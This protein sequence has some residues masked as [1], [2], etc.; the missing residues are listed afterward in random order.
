MARVQ[1]DAWTGTVQ[2]IVGK[3]DT[4][5]NQRGVYLWLSTDGKL[6]LTWSADGITPTTA[7]STAAVP[8][9]TG[10]T[11]WVRAQHDVDNGAAGNNVQFYTGT[12]GTNYTQLGGTVTTAGVTSHFASTADWSIGTRSLTSPID[13][14]TGRVYEVRIQSGLSAA[15]YDVMPNLPELYEPLNGVGGTGYTLGGSPVLALFSASLGGQNVTYFDNST[16]R[17]KLYPNLGQRL[18]F[19]NTA[20]ND[21]GLWTWALGAYQTWL[22]NLRALLPG[23]PLVCLGQNPVSTGA[24]IPTQDHVDVRYARN[25]ALLSWAA[26]GAVPGTWPIDMFPA[27][28]AVFD[29]G[30]YTDGYL[31]PTPGLTGGSG[32]MASR[33]LA[34]IF[35][36][37]TA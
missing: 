22:T 28:P 31:H 1:P 33:L 6:N 18:L 26:S 5:S 24:L 16:R 27:W 23:V 32:L 36:S 19:T 25:A 3:Y 34:G 10:Q 14:L 8:F 4:A 37:A 7:T 21:P 13:F 2:A 17:P 15:A 35:G 29:P 12:D 20:M 30:L 11:G 9:T